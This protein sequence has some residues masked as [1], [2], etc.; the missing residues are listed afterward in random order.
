MGSER[1][2][3]DDDDDEGRASRIVTGTPHGVSSNKRSVLSADHRTA[4]RVGLR[5]LSPN[6]L[7]F[8]PGL[9]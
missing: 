3:D 2:R 1:E 9:K 5:A 6:L 8:M 7:S 4:L